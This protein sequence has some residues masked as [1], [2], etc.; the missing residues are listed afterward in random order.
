MEKLGKITT[1]KRKIY[2]FK[3]LIKPHL[4]TI[5]IA[6]GIVALTII[7]LLIKYN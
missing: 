1:P 4:E 5:F 2:Y 7:Y 6:G 3:R